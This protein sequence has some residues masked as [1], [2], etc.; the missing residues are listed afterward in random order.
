MNIELSAEQVQ[1]ICKRLGITIKPPLRAR[2]LKRATE[3]KP[4]GIQSG[5][6]RKLTR[7]MHRID[8]KI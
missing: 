7:R 2:E 3:S 5:H 1:A 8:E 6:K 4:N